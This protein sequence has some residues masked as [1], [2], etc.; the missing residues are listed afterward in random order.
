MAATDARRSSYCIQYGPLRAPRSGLCRLS[1]TCTV[2]AGRVAFGLL[3]G[4]RTAWIP[5]A[6]N[7]SGDAARRQFDIAADLEDGQQCWLV[8]S[9]DHPDGDG[10]S[11]FVIHRL[12]GSEDPALA[13]I[14]SALRARPS[15]LRRKYR[16]GA[17]EWADLLARSVSSILGRRLRYRVARLAPEF[18]AVEKALRDSDAQLRALAPLGYLRGFNSFLRERRPANLHQNGCGDFQ[19]MAREH[20]FELRGYPEFQMFSMNIDGFFTSMAHS[21]GVQEQALE[22]PLCIYHLE[23]EKGSGWTPE[24]EAALRK[25]IAESGITWLENETVHILGTYMEWFGRPMILN[26]S[27]WGFGEKVLP[28]TIHAS[29]SSAKAT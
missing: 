23:H 3:N 19:L 18:E 10:V 24:G 20:W 21:A 13:I 16:R 14:E 2:M 29:V 7:R 28:D 8:V 4:E 1:V 25:R 5:A 26:G 22:S 15:W 12:D 17:S 6:V 11:K 9:N 27:G